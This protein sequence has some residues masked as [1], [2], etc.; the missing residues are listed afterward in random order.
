MAFLSK[1]NKKKKWK[2]LRQPFKTASSDSASIE[3][4]HK[5]IYMQIIHW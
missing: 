4:K 2:R 3:Y 1:H 5:Y